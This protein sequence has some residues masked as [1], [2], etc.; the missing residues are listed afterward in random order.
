MKKLTLAAAAGA[1]MFAAPAYADTGWYGNLGYTHFDTSDFTA[2]ALT[3]RVGHSFNENFALEG[4]LNFGVVDDEVTVLGTKVDVGV[5]YAYG[6]FGVGKLPVA[7]GTDL[8]A[9]V[10]YGSIEGEASVSG[11]TISDSEDGLAYGVGAQ[12]MLT[13]TVGVRGDYTRLDGDDDVDTFSVSALF[14]F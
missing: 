11:L 5:D 13:E 6:V 8:F 3:G 12:T 4:E 14:K 1:A 9:R 10:G 7:P 2:G